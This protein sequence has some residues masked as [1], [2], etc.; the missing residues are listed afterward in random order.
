MI[1]CSNVTAVDLIKKIKSAHKKEFQPNQRI[2]IYYTKGLPHTQQNIQTILNVI[3]ISNFFVCVVSTQDYQNVIS[4]DSIPFNFIKVDGQFD[5][6]N[7][8]ELPVTREDIIRQ[9]N[10]LLEDTPELL[11]NSKHFCMAPWV[12]LFVGT[13]GEARLCCSQYDT[14]GSVTENSLSELQNN[15]KIDTI[16]N[17]LKQDLPITGCERCYKEESLGRSSSR[18]AFNQKY[19][20]H[21]DRVEN[22]LPTLLHWDFRFSNLCNLSCRSCG[23]QSSTSWY[24]PA[25]VIGVDKPQYVCNDNSVYK[26]LLEYVDQVEEI[27]FAGGEPL[28][29]PE[30]YAVLNKLIELGRTDVRLVYNT[31]LTEVSFKGQSVFDLWNKFDNVAVCASLDACNER[32]EYLRCGTNWKTIED[33]RQAM[34]DACPDIYF[35]VSATTGMINALHVP[36]FHRDWVERGLINPE[37]F[38][39]QNIYDPDYMRVDR[40]TAELR[41]LIVSKYISHLEWLEPSDV[42]GRATQGYKGI[43]NYLSNLKGF[44]KDLFWSNIKPL[45]EYYGVDLL[46][47][48]PELDILPKP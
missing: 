17:Q 23:P 16:R 11:A 31:N 26:Q 45:D 20:H 48:F 7:N 38:N 1:D 21:Y 32:G 37:N 24:K 5:L 39:I 27:Y 2:V 30:H 14:I 3:D 15:N 44:D 22:N 4:T 47:A 8:N 25:K 28:I 40:A 12:H 29:M 13:Q 41:D 18:I 34:I 6:I 33:N 19:G 9:S 42:E 46:D 36:D 10:S 43:I 35:W